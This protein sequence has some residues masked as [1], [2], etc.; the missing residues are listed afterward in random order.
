MAETEKAKCDV[1]G[2][3]NDAEWL[4]DGSY[5]IDDD[6]I[7]LYISTL[8]GEE[9]FRIPIKEEAVKRLEGDKEGQPRFCTEHKDHIC[10]EVVDTLQQRAWDEWHGDRIRISLPA[11]G[12]IAVPAEVSDYLE[13]IEDEVYEHFS[14]VKAQDAELK[15]ALRRALIKLIT[16]RYKVT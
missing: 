15:K 13:R 3:E 9:D 14:R 16:D 12:E 6:V 7:V 11:R 4:Y 1:A 8:G 5:Y 2:C 10:E